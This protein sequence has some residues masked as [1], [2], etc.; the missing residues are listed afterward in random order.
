MED[1]ACRLHLS[2]GQLHR[3]DPGFS[4]IKCVADDP[5]IKPEIILPGLRFVKGIAEGIMQLLHGSRRGIDRHLA[6]LH[7]AE[8]P[9]IIKSHDMIRV[10]MG[11]ERCIE[12]LHPFPETL[13]SELGSRIDH[14]VLI[15][16]LNQNGTAGSGVTRVV[17]EADR[18][19]ATDNGNPLR[20][21]CTEKGEF[22]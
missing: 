20:S 16:C 6:I 10:G 17:G 1:K 13:K 22:K 3:N 15:G 9:H 4:Q 18:A 19:V 21:A 8:A 2:M 14:E 11:E 12:S 5:G 7:L